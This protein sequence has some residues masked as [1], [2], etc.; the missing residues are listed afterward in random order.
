MTLEELVEH[1]TSS[2][3]TPMN[4]SAVRQHLDNATRLDVTVGAHDAL[5]LSVF[6]DALDS[7]HHVIVLTQRTKQDTPVG[8]MILAR[9]H[10]SM[11]WQV[12]DVELDSDLRGKGL[13]TNLYRGL[14]SAGY[15][16]QSGDVLSKD[17]ERVWISLGAAGV[18]KTLDTETGSVGEFDHSPTGDGSLQAGKKP[19]F[20]WVTEGT[21][22]P[23]T[24]YRAGTLTEQQRVDWIDG[25]D[26][27]RNT[28]WLHGVNTIAIDGNV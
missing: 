7:N 2:R 1:E 14:T 10:T 27:T 13:I 23:T 9:P 19:R 24:Y 8:Y 12:V 11:R 26:V 21:P 22:L 18:A 16:L 4:V 25:V 28:P 3:P 6:R 5:A 15:Q 20:Y 17:A